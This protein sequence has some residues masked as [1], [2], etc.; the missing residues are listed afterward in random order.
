M[1]FYRTLVRPGLFRLNPETVHQRTVELCRIA[2]GLPLVP[3]LARF[4]WHFTA[5]ELQTE[6]AGLR[7]ENPV[8]LAAGRDKSG[9]ALRMLDHQ[10]FGFTEI[11]SVSARPSA[12]NPKPRLF[13]LP[14]DRAIVVIY[15]VPNDGAE[16]VSQRLAAYRPLVPLGVNLVKTNQRSRRHGHLSGERLIEVLGESDHDE[17]TMNRPANALCC[18]AVTLLASAT[19]TPAA[20]VLPTGLHDLRIGDAAPDFALP[21]IDGRTHRLADY[22]SAKLPGRYRSKWGGSPS[23]Q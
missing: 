2:G 10:G 11:G 9:Q 14:L 19:I 17:I 23:L 3:K 8:G 16:V 4:R 6:V 18:A 12:G 22:R 7:V 1:S 15:G 21:G 5:P 20:T 13:R